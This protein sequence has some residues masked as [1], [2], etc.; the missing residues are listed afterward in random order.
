MGFSDKRI[1][2]LLQTTEDDIEKMRKTNNIKPV[3]KRVDTCAAEFEAHTPYLYSTY[4]EE[5][6]SA[7]TRKNKIVILGSGPNR[8]GQGIEFD[9]A[10]VHASQSL[11][12]E[13]YETIMINCNP[14]TVSTDYDISSRLYFEPITEE[15]VV[16]ILEIEK[17][18]G[19]ILQYGGQTPL[20]LSGALASRKINILGTSCA[21]LDICE[22]REK[23]RKIIN[24]I[25]L[26]QPENK[27]ANSYEEARIFATQ[28]GFP[29]IIR[30]S[31][32]LGGS[33]MKII[34]DESDLSDYLHELS[35]KQ[36][37]SLYPILIEKFITGAY[38]LDV[39]A[40]SD[41]EDVFIAGIMEHIEEAGVHSG[42]S[43]CVL[44]PISIKE[45]ILEIIKNQVKLLAKKL[46]IIGLINIQF[47]LKGR[48]IYVIEVNPRASRTIPF[49]SKA[50]GIPIAKIA[51][52]LMVGKKL[53]NFNLSK[54]Q[55][56]KTI[57]C[58]VPVFSFIKFPQT[59]IILGPEMK[60]TGE[61]MSMDYSFEKAIGKALLASGKNLPLSGT[62]FIS[63]KDEDKES[64]IWLAKKLEAFGFH[65][66]GTKGTANF[67][68]RVGIKI[69][70]INKVQEG[71]P[72]I[73]DKIMDNKVD[74]V[75]NTTQGKKAIL[76]SH[77][78]RYTALTKNI[79]YFVNI[80]AANAAC[81]AI[82]T[83]KEKKLAYIAI[84]DIV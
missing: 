45:N 43:S 49:V 33:S 51:A 24:D 72:N 25:N 57:S 15:D 52:K 3:Y 23:F 36:T 84:Q 71:R 67:L 20:K 35:G 68:S 56:L 38:E 46:K 28:L 11:Q 4:E 55:N 9:Y 26:K 30:P 77:S 21:N 22:D 54:R 48:D 10:C 39:D 79:P 13:G 1:A 82:S 32:V 60:S 70:K 19:V 53:R 74:L 81:L 8:I 27:T 83:L 7:V 41:G 12:E 14:E 2:E 40:M 37:S 6:E 5:D 63:V 50:I 80:E 59:D 34:Y 62:V 76:D 31:Y 73:V 44:P 75:I 69:K 64:V 65:L 42:D 47:A 61:V 58:K 18:L 78:I 17:P 29:I 16:N 66:I